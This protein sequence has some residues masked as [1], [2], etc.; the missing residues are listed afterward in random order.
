MW[1]SAAAAIARLAPREGV[2]SPDLK[3]DEEREALAGNSVALRRAI[4]K[5]LR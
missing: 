4:R 5:L 2:S 3:R 1:R